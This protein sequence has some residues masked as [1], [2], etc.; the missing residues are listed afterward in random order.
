MNQQIVRHHV[1]YPLYLLNHMKLDL[2]PCCL[3][4]VFYLFHHQ[5]QL[6]SI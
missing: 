4:E 2:L 6:R 5:K 3:G 1:L